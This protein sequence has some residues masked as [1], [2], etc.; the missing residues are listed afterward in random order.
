SPS[1]AAARGAP[2]PPTPSTRRGRR[3]RCRFRACC[4]RRRHVV[5]QVGCGR[6][7]CCCCR[8]CCGGCWFPFYILVIR[9]E[10]G[11]TSGCRFHG[12]RRRRSLFSSHG[13]RHLPPLP[14]SLSS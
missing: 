10:A 3:R 6:C 7:C 5:A 1:T 11:Q 2:C 8:G 14:L 9:H 4:R 12:P 13:P